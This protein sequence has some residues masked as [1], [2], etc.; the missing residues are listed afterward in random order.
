ME[1]APQEKRRHPRQ[2]VLT[3]VMVQPNG[4]RHEAQVLDLSLGGARVRRPSD[5]NPS[6]GAA[7]RMFFEVGGED[8]IAL[9]GHVSRV[10]VDHMGVSFDD[11]QED[12]VQQLFEAIG[13][14][15]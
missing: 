12:R 14:R 11:A 4:H 9:Q 1:T 15:H 5:W 13:K 7:L 10:S 2:S 3:A 6:D 8:E